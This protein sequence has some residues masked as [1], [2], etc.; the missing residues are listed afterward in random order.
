[1]LQEPIQDLVN[2]YN[3]VRQHSINICKPLNT[4]DYLIQLDFFVSPARWSLGHTSWFFE[5]FILKNFMNKY[6]EFHPKYNFLFNSYYNN[7]GERT[8]RGNRGALSRPTV[9]EVYDYRQY[10][11]NNME[12]LITSGQL[13]ETIQDLIMLG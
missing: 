7:M 8:L 10:V 4:E 6:K 9:K 5:E 3:Q 12:S 11:D 2:N 1:M 13:N